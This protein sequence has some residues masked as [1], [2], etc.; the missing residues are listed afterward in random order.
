ML[1]DSGA[2]AVA[3]P[4]AATQALVQRRQL[5]VP[6]VLLEILNVLQK[7]LNITSPVNY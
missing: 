5:L 3:Q 7:I 2:G 6:E 1:A 4:A